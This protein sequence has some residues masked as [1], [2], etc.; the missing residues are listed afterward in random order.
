MNKDFAVAVM[1]Q[2]R[3]WY[4]V[5]TT[6]NRPNSLMFSET[7]EPESCPDINEIII[8]QNLRSADYI[9]ALIPYAGALIACQSRHC[10]S[11]LCH[12]L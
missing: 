8:Q 6:N 5:D 11:D 4:A 2:D 9:T 12:N 3:L 7:D 10:H 1:F